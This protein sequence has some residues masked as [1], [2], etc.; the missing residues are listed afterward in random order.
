MSTQVRQWAGRHKHLSAAILIGAVSFIWLVI[1]G[2]AA[3]LNRVAGVL[4]TSLLLGLIVYMSISFVQRL[5]AESEMVSA[6][7]YTLTTIALILLSFFVFI[8]IIKRM[9]EAA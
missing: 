4:A 7:M 2:P 6:V 9:W 8:W 3:A 5:R 1:G